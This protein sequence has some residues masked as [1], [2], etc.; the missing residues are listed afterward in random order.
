[1]SGFR[2]HYVAQASLGIHCV[3]QVG[4]ELPATLLLLPP[5]CLSCRHAPHSPT[6]LVLF[7]FVNLSG[8][9]VIFQAHKDRS[10]SP[11]WMDVPVMSLCYV[12]APAAGLGG[13]GYPF[14][15]HR[16]GYLPA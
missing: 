14:W 9:W 13:L 12:L 16:H 8:L 3:A 10:V 11:L 1:M 4:L 15:V 6:G 2:S 7:C 5:E